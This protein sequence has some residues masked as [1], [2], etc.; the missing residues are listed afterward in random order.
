MIV[1]EN[2][3]SY[4]K[5]VLA[6]AIGEH[7]MKMLP[8]GDGFLHSR[9]ALDLCWE[10]I[11]EWE[12]V[13]DDVI[14]DL[15]DCIDPEDLIEFEYYSD[16]SEDATISSIYILLL[17]ISS[18]I[19]AQVL[20]AEVSPR[21]QYLGFLENDEGYTEMILDIVKKV[22][23]NYFEE[24]KLQEVLDYCNKKRNEKANVRFRRE[25]ILGIIF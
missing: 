16:C 21:P 17:G 8:K 20:I 15:C 25:E 18:Y 7:V 1:L 4:M 11:E 9:K 6:V 3:N 14:G 23:K 2:T 19:D 24:F 22:N 5:A 13:A 12:K 10:C